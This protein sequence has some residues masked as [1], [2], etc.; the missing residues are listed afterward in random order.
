MTAA[1]QLAAF[2][3]GLTF[4]AI[5]PAVVARAKACIADAVACAI[6]G[7]AQPW[8]RMLADHARRYG[9]GG[10]ARLLG[11]PADRVHA[12]LAALA[13]GT[14]AH[15]FELDSLTQPSS[16]AH[17]GA[18]LC[19]A[20]WALAEERGASGR[21][22]VTA[23]V[24]GCEAMIRVGASLGHGVERIG[25]HGPGVTGPIG[26]AIACA[27]LLGLDTAQT[28]SAIGLSGSFTGGLL[29]FSHATGGGMV[30]RLHLGRAA[31]AGVVAASLAA[32][33][34]EGPETVLD[35]KAGV[36]GAFTREAH[37]ER[38]TAGLGTLWEVL[39][40]TLKR[41]PAH[42]TAHVPL[43]L[44]EDLRREGGFD[45]SAVRSIRLGVSERVLERHAIHEPADAMQAQYSVPFCAAV[46]L[47]RDARDPASFSPDAV[48]DPRV[49]QTA[50]AIQ[51]EANPEAGAAGW[52]SRVA[53]ELAD[54]RQFER[55]AT[56][57][58]GAATNPMSEDERRV[59][60]LLLTRALGEGPMTR[61]FA[62]IEALEHEGS[63][64]GLFD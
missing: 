19:M 61:L 35:G 2:A 43:Q 11:T 34:Y 40:I 37:P 28:V 60:F 7:A 22:L 32:Q 26:S 27:R 25:F 48:A 30:K 23:F 63:I 50:K 62:R 15:A 46:G 57:F 38:L 1:A 51:L 4:E 8:G 54:G 45:G 17:P 58:R 16:A 9:G 10:A 18:T 14:A 56:D 12:P 52:A 24:A 13:N 6:H 53:I 33:G 29:A 64:S 55:A 49:R 5:P 47:W 21:E 3:H 44:I 42:I 41:Y 36:L 20:L 31:E 59:K 39:R